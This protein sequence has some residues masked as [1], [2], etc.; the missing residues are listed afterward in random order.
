MVYGRLLKRLGIIPETEEERLK[1]ISAIIDNDPV[2]NK[3]NKELMAINDRS[4]GYLNKL[5]A[6]DP[7][8]HQWLED[9]GMINT[10]Y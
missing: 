3:L 5:K 4:K 9:N 1:R 8:L 10:K 6:I 7:K 2:L